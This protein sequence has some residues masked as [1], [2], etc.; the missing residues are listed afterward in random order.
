MNV[1][2]RPF[3]END[4]PRQVEIV[5]LIYPDSP[6]S[7]EMARFSDSIWD[8]QRHF[9]R[10][11]LAES[12]TG[13][14]VGWGEISHSPYSFHPD[15]YRLS[16]FVDPAVQRHGVG[17]TLYARLIA[18][19]RERDAWLVRTD[20]KESQPHSVAFLTTRGFQDVQRA[21]E[22]R[23]NVPAFDFT[24]FARAE[25]RVT[26]RGITLTTFAAEGPRDEHVRRA[27][28]E[29]DSLCTKDEPS[30]DPITPRPYEQFVKDEYEAPNTLPEAF[31]LAKD[32]SR[33][34]GLSAL[35]RNLTQ[36]DVLGQGF[37]AVHPDYRGRGIAMAM[38][39]RGLRYARDHG[40][41]EIRTHNNTRNGPML[42]INEALG[43]VK[44]PVWIEFQLTLRDSPVTTP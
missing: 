41:R 19:L 12:S 22:S 10:R 4:Y 35:G 20:A 40:H 31:I 18:E 32:G 9:K 8:H 30:V 38:K 33:Y 1:S 43:F 26:E 37:T 15:K 21:W 24:P 23:L 27:V 29:L 25:A 6:G 7:V 17:S 2:I 5:D 42:R 44:Q 16:L 13:H 36:P 28:Y 11:L 34:V 3:D 39:L 14:V